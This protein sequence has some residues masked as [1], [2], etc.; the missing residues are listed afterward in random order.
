K[1]TQHQGTLDLINNYLDKTG[2]SCSFGSVT[3]QPSQLKVSPATMKQWADEA[4]YLSKGSPLTTKPVFKYV[5]K[6]YFA[7]LK[8]QTHDSP[9]PFRDQMYSVTIGRRSTPMSTFNVIKGRKFTSDE[10]PK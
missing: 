7:D 5:P 3:Y 4:L 10:Q 8:S 2:F 9:S 6:S 1:Q